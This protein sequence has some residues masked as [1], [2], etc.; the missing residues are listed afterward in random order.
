MRKVTLFLGILLLLS[1]LSLCAQQQMV[2]PEQQMQK[3]MYEGGP[4][5]KFAD[6]V[7]EV[8][9]CWVNVPLSIAYHA[10]KIDP[11]SSAIIGSASG[12]ALGIRDGIEGT[13]GATFCI[14]PPYKKQKT[15]VSLLK[16]WDREIQERYW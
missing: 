14:A 1:P 9:F 15:V 7:A 6:S 11:L 13:L 10:E 8:A 3:P 16:K 2:V 12:T 4:V 5:S